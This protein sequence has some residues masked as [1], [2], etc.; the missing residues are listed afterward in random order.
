MRRIS[1]WLLAC[2]FVVVGSLHLIQ[3]RSFRQIVP[4]KIPKPDLVVALSGIA[5]I[6]GGVAILVPAV[7]PAAGWGLAVLLVAVL[8]A[9]VYMATNRIEPN[10]LHIPVALLW[11]RVTLQP[12]LIWWVMAAAGS[13]KRSDPDR[14]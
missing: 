12:L 3:P 11:T 5:E 4:P 2:L 1:L 10:G 14:R 6:L 7:R 9:N 8:P 13:L